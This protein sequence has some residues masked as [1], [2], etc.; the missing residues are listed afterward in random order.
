MLLTNC[1]SIIWVVRL[2]YQ[3][4][5]SIFA[6]NN[7]FFD[8]IPI[9]SWR[10]EQSL[11]LRSDY[12]PRYLLN[13]E[14]R[15]S[16]SRSSVGKV[17]DPTAYTLKVKKPSGHEQVTQGIDLSEVFKNWWKINIPNWWFYSWKKPLLKWR[18]KAY[19]HVL[20]WGYPK[21]KTQY[22]DGR[23]CLCPS[24]VVEGSNFRQQ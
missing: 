6:L 22:S 20:C 14:T 18:L 1:I 13:V 17:S 4:V 8:E 11:S 2:L 3:T 5:S 12:M 21:R 15:S 23:P 10:V 24:K 7:L 9:R 16:H 19:C